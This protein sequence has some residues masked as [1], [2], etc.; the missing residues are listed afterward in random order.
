M[1]KWILWLMP[2]YDK[3]MAQHDNKIRQY[4]KFRH[5]F[6]FIKVSMTRKSSSS[7]AKKGVSKFCV[8]KA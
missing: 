7:R 3:A 6:E 4:D 1:T 2:Q 5:L 8:L